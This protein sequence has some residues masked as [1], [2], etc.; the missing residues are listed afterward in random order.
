MV[1]LKGNLIPTSR[2]H[3]VSSNVA[4]ACKGHTHAKRK[5]VTGNNAGSLHTTR[6]FIQACLFHTSSRIYIDLML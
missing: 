2:A 5:F 3:A 1:Q 6:F 4:C